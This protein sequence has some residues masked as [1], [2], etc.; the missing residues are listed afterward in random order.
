MADFRAEAT[1][2]V[3][4][5]GLVGVGFGPSNLALAIA[6]DEL[7]PLFSEGRPLRHCFFERQPTFAWHSGMLL[8]GAQMRISF[9]KDLVTLRNPV[10]RFSFISYLQAK[11]RLLDF[12]NKRS[13]F[14][15]RIE[16]HDYLEWAASSFSSHV[17]Y[18]CS[19]RAIEPVWNDGVVTSF[20]LEV[21]RHDENPTTVRAENVVLAVGL[22]PRLPRGMQVSEHVWHNSELLLRAAAITS[23]PRRFVVIGAGQSAAETAQFLHRRFTEAEICIVLSRYGF[24]Q[25]DDSAFASRLYDPEGVEVF[26]RA[27]EMV[28]E[29]LLD[30]HRNSNDSV[31]DGELIDQLYR[32]A[33]EEGVQERQR[34]RLLN[35]ST[36]SDVREGVDVAHVT[37]KSRATEEQTVL[38]ADGVVYAT[39]Y[40]PPDPRML[41]SG[42]DDYLLCDTSGRLRVRDDYRIETAPEVRAGI[43]LQGGLEH[44]DGLS[45]NLLSN[46]ALRAER[47]RTSLMQDWDSVLEERA[48]HSSVSEH[49]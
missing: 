46:V 12:I 28:K 10:S 19:V 2:E 9:I 25:T 41:L 49:V 30:Y 33:Y 16:F 48:G 23:S 31:V 47:I 29:A 43:F 22:E 36:V 32:L 40:A 1:A 45:S 13:F 42:L 3:D 6:F 39:G 24:S 44:L 15:S 14:P 11:G 4:S 27:P 26:R 34:L 35:I 20:D 7:S 37:V 18:D 38:D 5:Y 17:E 8:E 21:S